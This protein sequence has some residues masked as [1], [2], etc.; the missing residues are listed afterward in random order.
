MKISVIIPVYNAEIYLNKCLTSIKNQKNFKDLEIIIINDGSTDNSKKIIN[1]FKQ[2]NKNII[3]KNLDHKGV[4]FA[5]NVGIDLATSKYITFVDSDDYLENDCYEPLL[6][7]IEVDDELIVSGFNIEYENSKIKLKRKNNK[8]ENLYNEKIMEE[9]IYGFKISPNIWNKL[10]LTD[11]VKQIK[12]DE[13]LTIAEDKWFVFQ[14]LT[15]V[16]K[17]KIQSNTTYNYI[18]H[19]I[20]I[21]NEKFNK[22]KF[23]SIIVSGRIKKHIEKYYPY[24]IDI[25]ECYDIDV[26]CRV[27]GTLSYC[28][29]KN[30][31]KK[32]YLTLKQE[33]K[34][35]PIIKKIKYSNIKHSI[36][37]ILIKISPR[38]YIFVQKKLKFQY[39][40]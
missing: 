36:A 24:L 13:N 5:R 3:V 35:F 15:K 29:Y 33:I 9:F 31:Y 19:D 25:V 21:C 11:I 7:N 4:S 26:K 39:L 32:E 14:Y 16:K 23:D 17:V 30:K 6:K 27:F 22:K 18:I 2:E 12:F 34:K 1:K 8:I 28:E 20:S 37:F 10:F 38:L 40:T